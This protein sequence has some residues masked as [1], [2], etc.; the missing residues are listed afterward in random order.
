MERQLLM[1]E[2]GSWTTKVIKL[3]DIHMLPDLNTILRSPPKK[4]HWASMVNKAVDAHHIEELTEKAQQYS[5]LRYLA[6][7]NT[8]IGKCHPI[9]QSVKNNTMDTYRG[10]IKLRLATGTYALQSNRRAAN[11]AV[12]DRTCPLCKQE[13]ESRQHLITTCAILNSIRETYKLECPVEYPEDR[14]NL[15]QMVLDASAEKIRNTL[16]EVDDNTRDQIECWS[17]RLCYA[18]HSERCKRLSELPAMKKKG[19]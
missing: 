5:S 12:V 1:Q 19:K 14:E 16:G 7:E 10:M 9:I 17:R 18:L 15:L 2:K 6:V 4:E 8:K 11:Q 13:V 3:L